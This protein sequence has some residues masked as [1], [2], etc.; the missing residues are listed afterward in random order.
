MAKFLTRK[1]YFLINLNIPTYDVEH[2]S[3]DMPQCLSTVL[4]GQVLPLVQVVLSQ[5]KHG[6]LSIDSCQEERHHGGHL[7]VH[8]EYMKI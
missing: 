3:G 4:L 1:L 5:T 6:A 7:H 2:Y 8:V